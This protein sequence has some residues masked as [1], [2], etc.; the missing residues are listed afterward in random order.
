MSA[1]E[2]E[3]KD[4]NSKES[5][6]ITPKKNGFTARH[7]DTTP[8][9][10]RYKNTTSKITSSHS[11]SDDESYGEDG[12][13]SEY[14]SSDD[15][16]EM[17]TESEGEAD[18]TSIS[19]NNTSPSQPMNTLASM[20]KRNILRET[21]TRVMTPEIMRKNSNRDF[22]VKEDDWPEFPSFIDRNVMS[23]SDELAVIGKVINPN[24]YVKETLALRLAIHCWWEA[25][26]RIHTAY[27]DGVSTTTD[28]RVQ[29][30]LLEMRGYE[31]TIRSRLGNHNNNFR[32]N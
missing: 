13:S 17:S 11:D 26:K 16:D 2:L 18:V 27:K 7:Y 9:V 25:I 24:D 31:E 28:Q 4:V 32:L 8:T 10:P 3:D 21:S 6:S 19:W 29:K 15:S 23:D 5:L 14:S 1:A 22:D 20:M 12:S 30:D